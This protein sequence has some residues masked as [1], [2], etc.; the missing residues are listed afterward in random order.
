MLMMMFT[1][2]VPL[3]ALI[4]LVLEPASESLKM[5]E[6]AL[7]RCFLDQ[8]KLVLLYRRPETFRYGID[9]RHI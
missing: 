1:C 2:Q 9:Y 5:L 4:S 7:F 6:A 3:I 8:K